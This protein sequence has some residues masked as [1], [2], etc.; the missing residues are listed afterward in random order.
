MSSPS[1][2]KRRI[3]TDVIKLIESKHEVTI[4]GGLNEF[5]VKFFGPSGSHYEGGVWKVRVDLPEKYPFKSPSIGFINKI[6]HPNIDEASGT[7]CLDVINQAW[8]A[9]Y[10]LSNIFESFLP[11]LLSYPNPVDPLNGDAAALYL[12][13]PEQYKAKIQEYIKKY[14]TE[15]ALKDQEEMS[16]SSE[17]S[18]SDFSEDEAQDM[19]L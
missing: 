3:D 5:I 16:S 9:L 14:A 4:L 12:H 15:E 2:G 8:T 11:Q 6:F 17:S 18:I 19:E 13:K 10:D 7:V 1:P